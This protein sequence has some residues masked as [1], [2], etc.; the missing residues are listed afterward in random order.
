M[1]LFSKLWIGIFLLA[2]LSPL[3]LFLPK[4]FKSKGAW[5]EEKILNLW[6]APIPDY[7]LKI[8]ADKGLGHLSISYIISAFLGIVITVSIVFLIV[9][10]LT[11]K[12]E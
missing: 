9:R 11:K 2:I 8:H 4:F 1:K 5:G 3:G 6:K 12:G 7:V 10:P